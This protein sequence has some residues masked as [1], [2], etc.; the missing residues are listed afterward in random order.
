MKKITKIFGV[1]FATV[2]TLSLFAAALPISASPGVNEFDEIGMPNIAD[3][4]DA[5][6]VVIASDGTMFAAVFDADDDVWDIK[7]STDGGFTW[8]DTTLTGLLEPDGDPYWFV[9][10][11]DT[12]VDIAVSPAWPDDQTV[13]V[14]TMAGNVYRLP[15]AGAGTPVLLK[16]I[17]DSAGQTLDDVGF[18]FAY[19]L[20]IWWDGSDNWI[21]VACDLDVLVLRDALFEDWRDQELAT[22]GDLAEAVQVDFAP[23]FDTSNLLWAITYNGGG[24]DS[25]LVLTST[26]SPGQWGNTIDPVDLDPLTHYLNWTPFV[27]IAF[28]DDYDSELPTLYV[29]AA[30]WPGSDEGNLFLINGAMLPG[31]S[32]CI[33]LFL[34]DVDVGSVE[35][36]G[37][38]ILVIETWT[39]TIWVSSNAGDTFQ[40]A[41]MSPLGFYWGRLAM[42]NDFATSGIAFVGVMDMGTSG[43][44][45][46]RT[47]DG[48]MYWNGIGL[49]D[50]EIEYIVDVAFNPASNAALLLTYDDYGFDDDVAIWYTTDATADDPQWVLVGSEESMGLWDIENVTWSLDASSVFIT[51]W[52]GGAIELWKSTD[53]GMSFDHW[54]TLPGTVTVVNDMIASDGIEIMLA[55]DAGF[56]ATHAFGPATFVDALTGP[57]V[58]LDMAADGTLALGGVDGAIATSDDGGVTWDVDD[59]GD[60]D[61]SV[62]FG[63]DGTLY[64]ATSDSEVL[65]VD[66]TDTSDFEALEDSLDGT[67][68]ADSFSGI[69]VAPD[70]AVYAIGGD[71]VGAS[72]LGPADVNVGTI[73]LLSGVTVQVN[74]FD[75]SGFGIATLTGTFVDGEDIT[76]LAADV[77]A[78]SSSIAMGDIY[79]EG[80]ISGATGIITIQVYD[81]TNPFQLITPQ[82]VYPMDMGIVEGD[83][84]IDTDVS[85]IPGV[86]GDTNMFRL[87]PDVSNNEWETEEIDGA[88]GIWGTN[89]SNIVWTVVEGDELWALEDTLTVAPL[90]VSP[91]NGATVVGTASATLTWTLPDGAKDV[92]VV[93][94]GG[95]V[96]TITV[97]SDDLSATVT[98]LTDNTEYTW[99]VQVPVD[100]PFQSPKSAYWKFTTTDS[101]EPPVV[102]PS[103]VPANGD[104]NVPVAGPAFAWAGV[105]ALDG[106]LWEL[107]TDPLFGTLVAEADLAVSYYVHSGTLDY[108]TAY[109][110]RVAAYSDVG[111]ISTWV[112]SVF[113]TETPAADPVVVEENPPTVVTLTIPEDET[114]TYI[115]AIIFIGLLL[116]IAVIILLVRTRRVV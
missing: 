23:D 44:G 38:D 87:L 1:V 4:T 90:L 103:L 76:I 110:W 42:A 74:E 63:P 27:D 75:I 108:N 94:V 15:D 69:W 77:K 7:K 50:I 88:M 12:V 3:D 93:V 2:L 29:A 54:R 116:T 95:T 62:A 52:D 34:D 20:D 45:L 53:D 26:I 9:T 57:A 71:G 48:G 109:Y 13:Y 28:T 83:I 36:S 70:G 97:A 91:A 49:L 79:V 102:A 72:S 98:G 40:E 68:E 30:G 41:A 113:T 17:V 99:C 39:G 24:V 73:D 8:K 14:L 58:C 11:D 101:V 19:D 67:A 111:G 33:P 81:A 55:T 59:V 100:K 65:V 106:Y 5:G 86:T 89:G 96:G 37:N 60:G 92:V 85:I 25:D 82:F 64:A 21:A 56:Y 47:T 32:E 6:M 43:S 35:V 66:A 84:A 115:W 112:T 104:Y 46:Y 78:I 10:G 80:D 22:G 18:A 31:T 16:E 61:V 105:P 114:P 107:S 51:V